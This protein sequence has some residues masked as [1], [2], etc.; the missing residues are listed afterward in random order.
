MYMF[1]VYNL[2]TLVSIHIVSTFQVLTVKKIVFET[3]IQYLYCLNT[4]IVLKIFM[5]ELQE[6]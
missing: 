6:L 4:I 3:L 1:K 2:G 5:I